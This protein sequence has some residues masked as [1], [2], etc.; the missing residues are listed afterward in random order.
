M[1]T[2]RFCLVGHYNEDKWSVSRL[3]TKKYIQE[4]K[5]EAVHR[6]HWLLEPQVLY[7]A[8]EHFATLFNKLIMWWFSC[9]IVSNSWNPMDCSPPGYVLWDIA[10]LCP[11]D[12]QG[13]NTGMGCH[14]LLWG[15]FPTQES[16]LGLLNCR[17]ILYQLR[18][19]GSSN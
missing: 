8:A 9:K 14:F 15:I 17:Q 10:I 3:T 6:N 16:S 19:K 13:R 7:V 11:W 4:G 18:Y 1:H 12:S 2:F 5:I